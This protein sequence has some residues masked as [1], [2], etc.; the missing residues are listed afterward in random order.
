MRSHEDPLLSSSLLSGLSIDWSDALRGTKTRV[1]LVKMEVPRL[2]LGGGRERS[3]LRRKDANCSDLSTLQLIGQTTANP[4]GRAFAAR[5]TANG[6]QL[7][8]AGKQN[9]TRHRLLAIYAR[10]MPAP[11]LK[12]SADSS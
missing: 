6:T 5:T 9:A 12:R 3:I 8:A 1:M 10:K 7:F 11:Q 2:F 4:D